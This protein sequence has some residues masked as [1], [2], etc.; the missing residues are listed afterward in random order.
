MYMRMS[1]RG[2]ALNLHQAGRRVGLFM[3]HTTMFSSVY[4]HSSFIRTPLV[5]VGFWVSELSHGLQVDQAAR[6]L[7]PTYNYGAGSRYNF[8]AS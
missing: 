3:A 8:N 2:A 1:I 7:H 5:H 4:C 6:T